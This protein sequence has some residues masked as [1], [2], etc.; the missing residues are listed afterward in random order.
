MQER[1]WLRYLE[2]DDDQQLISFKPKGLIISDEL[3]EVGKYCRKMAYEKNYKLLFDFRNSSLT[4]G[5][6]GAYNWFKQYYSKDE[7]YLKHVKTAHLT[8]KDHEEVFEYIDIV[9]PAQGINTKTF[10]SKSKAI[11]W[12]QEE[13]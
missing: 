4:A 8:A 7:F 11:E 3:A 12:L 13:E 10:K 5:I 2:I 9:W 1:K 6:I